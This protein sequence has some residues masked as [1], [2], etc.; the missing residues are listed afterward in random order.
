MKELI[1]FQ[2]YWY[3]QGFFLFYLRNYSYKDADPV[4]PKL[5]ESVDTMV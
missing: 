2:Y 1:I 5:Q 4:Q 3:L